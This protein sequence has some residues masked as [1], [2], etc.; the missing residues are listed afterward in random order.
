MSINSSSKGLTSIFK[1]CFSEVKTKIKTARLIDLFSQGSFACPSCSTVYPLSQGEILNV[2]TCDKCSCPILQPCRIDNYLVFHPLGGGGMG[3]VYLCISFI[4]KKTYAIKLLPRKKKF[5]P[6]C[7]DNLIK[8]GCINK[9]IA[10]HK[11]IVGGVKFGI[12]G[13]E[14]FLVTELIKGERLDSFIETE[15]ALPQKNAID[16]ILQLINAEIHIFTKGYCYRDLKPENIIIQENGNV[17]LLDF[18]LT[19]RIKQA[20]F[21]D[22]EETI[23]EGSP[24]FLPP[25]RLIGAPEGEN[26]EIYSLGM[27][28]FFMLTARHYYTDKESNALAR[29]H[30]FGLRMDSTSRQLPN[31]TPEIVAVI[32]KMIQRDP[33]KRYQSLLPLRAHLEIIYKKK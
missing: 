22:L 13:D 25:E 7:V 24:H 3:S 15:G 18:G 5:D 6:M 4:N 16:I 21:P 27:L 19:L 9:D 29:K 31:C 8:E 26:S 33:E 2:I 10:G 23:I 32:D 17:K 11:N 1:K 20:A 30:V 12:Y 28:L 14:H